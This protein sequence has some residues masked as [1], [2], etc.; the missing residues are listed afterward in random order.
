LLNLDLSSSQLLS[1]SGI[2]S[3]PQTFNDRISLISNYNISFILPLYGFLFI[4]SDKLTTNQHISNQLLLKKTVHSFF[5]LSDLKS[6][7]AG[8]HSSIVNNY[9]SFFT[10]EDLGIQNTTPSFDNAVSS[11]MATFLTKNFTC[12]IDQASQSNF[13]QRRENDPRIPRFKFK[14]GYSRI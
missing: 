13:L 11:N 14:P 8:K 9:N 3:I 4:T 10:S 1:Y 5:Y 2:N 7:I 6:F 12:M